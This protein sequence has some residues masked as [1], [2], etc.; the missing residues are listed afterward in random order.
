LVANDSTIG[1][2]FSAALSLKAVTLL[3][4]SQGRSK[5]SIPNGT[6]LS[7]EETSGPFSL[8]VFLWLNELLFRGSRKVLG[9]KDLYRLDLAL[10]SKNL[11]P[12]IW[13]NWEKTMRNGRWGLMLAIA[14]SLDWSLFTPVPARLAFTRF[15]F[16]QP[17]LINGLLAYLQGGA[18]SRKVGFAWMAATAIICLGMSV[19]KALY[20]YKR[21][22]MQTMVRSLLVLT[23]VRKTRNSKS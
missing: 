13:V 1:K 18:K 16:C 4:Y 22:R 7:P 9:V 14:R 12:R 23:I 3:F 6:K 17:L 21:V 11:H 19:S 15:S 20:G 8:S 5:C 10:L 2:V